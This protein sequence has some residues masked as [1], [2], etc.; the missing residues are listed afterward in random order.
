MKE[1]DI[2]LAEDGE[3]FRDNYTSSV[4]SGMNTMDRFCDEY[5]KDLTSLVQEKMND[6]TNISVLPEKLTQYNIDLDSA[7]DKELIRS[8][9]IWINCIGGTEVKHLSNVLK[10]IYGIMK[11]NGYVATGFGITC[12]HE[13]ILIELGNIKPS[14]IESEDLEEVLQQ[15]ITETEYDG[16]TAFSKGQK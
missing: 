8:V 10:I 11:E 1:Q 7:F 13:G 9:D 4:T 15:A 12:E 5:K 2:T 3:I 14:H 6:V 16:I